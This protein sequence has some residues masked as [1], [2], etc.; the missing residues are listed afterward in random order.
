[1]LYFDKFVSLYNSHFPLKTFLVKEKHLGKPY[2]TPGIQKSINHRNKLQKLY[3]KWPLTY[4]TIFKKYRNM[5]TKII[6]VAKENDLKSK[7]IQESSDAR[8]I[9]KTINQL[10]GKTTNKLPSSMNFV[11]KTLSSDR[12]I[13]EEFNS[14]FSTVAS[15]LV[16][17]IEPTNVAY[18]SFLPAPVPFSFFLRPTTEQEI[19]DVIRSLK[20]TSPG[21]DDISIKILKKCPTEI[22]AFFKFF[23]NKCFKD[24]FFP[25]QLQIAKV[26]PI[27]KKGE[28]LVNT[29][30]RPVSILP[31]FSKIIEKKISVRLLDYFTK[32]SLFTKHQYGFRPKY[33]TELAIHQLCQSIHDALDNKNYQISVFCD[34][35]IAFDTVSHEILLKKKK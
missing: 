32:F 26:I 9:W 7:L 2:I 31:T 18:E 11:N 10:M 8:K 20:I 15:K 19:I 23:I 35:S 21:Y 13:T 29:N 22:S 5:L 34:L 1:M 25:K 14:Y 33:S 16:A 28:K 4:E 27:Y 24:G 6:R 17:D 30:Y 12:E 3:A